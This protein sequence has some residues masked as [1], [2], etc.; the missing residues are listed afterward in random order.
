MAA[1][2]VGGQDYRQ[3]EKQFS[4]RYLHL[5]TD[6]PITGV[7]R[8]YREYCRDNHADTGGW[9]EFRHWALNVYRGP[10]RT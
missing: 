2:A 6:K 1:M 9:N 7:L 3:A 5:Q 4:A 8:Q 10:A